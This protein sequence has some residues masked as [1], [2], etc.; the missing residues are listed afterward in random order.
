MNYEFISL[1]EDTIDI[2]P[3]KTYITY[4]Y[5]EPVYTHTFF[6][7]D[8]TVS[9]NAVLPCGAHSPYLPQALNLKSIVQSFCGLLNHGHAY[10]EVIQVSGIN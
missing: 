1:V 5:S 8:Q 9:V 7:V 6:K 2:T 4:R 10:F 3:V